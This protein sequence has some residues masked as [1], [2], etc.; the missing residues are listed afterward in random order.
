MLDGNA[1]SQRLD[2]IN[3]LLTY[4]FSMVDYPVE[5]AEG[6]LLIYL[7][8]DIEEARDRLVVS[9]MDTKRPAI[10]HEMACHLE[11]FMLHR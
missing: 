3:I 6:H 9:A 2:A 4:G 10:L 1:A 5:A 8:E 7:F 11:Q